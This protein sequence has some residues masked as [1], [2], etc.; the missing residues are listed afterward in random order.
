ME[1]VQSF[2]ETSSVNWADKPVMNDAFCLPYFIVK[3]RTSG[4]PGSGIRHLIVTS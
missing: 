2:V 3:H 4:R 1:I